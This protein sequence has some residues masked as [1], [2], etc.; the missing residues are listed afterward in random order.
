M[1]K[2]EMIM[3]QKFECI[4]KHLYK[5]Q[6]QTSS[7]D[8]STLY[9]GIFTDWRRVRRR[10]SLGEILGRARNKLGELR[11]KNDAEFD[12]DKDKADREA[13]CHSSSGGGSPLLIESPPSLFAS[14]VAKFFGPRN[15]LPVEAE[16]LQ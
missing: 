12:F 5:R 16:T 3:N 10:F 13:L 6:Y 2:K 11:R 1:Y 14:I 7:G 15:Y 4:E 9:Y 8:W